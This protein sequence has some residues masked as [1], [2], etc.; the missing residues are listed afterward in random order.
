MKKQIIT[1]ISLVILLSIGLVSADFP[2]IPHVFHG[3]VYYSDGNLIQE[4]FEIT[5]K[6]NDEEV[7]SSE[8]V[9]GEYDLAVAF[10]TGKTIYFYIEGIT[11]PIENY[12]FQELGRTE[13]N[14]IINITNPNNSS[15]NNSSSSSSSSTSSKRGSSGGSGP[16]G[17]SNDNIIN[18]DYKTSSLEGIGSIKTNESSEKTSSGITGSVIDFI[19]SG[20]V[21]ITFISLIGI[22]IVLMIIKKCRLK[23]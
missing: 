1:I 12:T 22:L 2:S 19:G 18:L 4:S 9:N 14:L 21:A 10:E 13:L 3:H 20:K 23:K 11:K 17:S 6:I 5:A 7:G 8:I 16:S 15:E